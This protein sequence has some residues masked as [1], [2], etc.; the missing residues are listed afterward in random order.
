MSRDVRT[1]SDK[2]LDIFG[3]EMSVDIS[4][5]QL[6]FVL[7]NVVAPPATSPG[8]G[9]QSDARTEKI[10]HALSASAVRSERAEIF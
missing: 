1:S 10:Q 6:E 4:C 8:G 9:L 2:C 7:V 3:A 5:M